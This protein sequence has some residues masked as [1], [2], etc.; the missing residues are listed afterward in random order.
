MTSAQPSRVLAV[1][2]SALTLAVL[3]LPLPAASSDVMP[4]R[5]D[6]PDAFLRGVTHVVCVTFPEGAE[7]E[8][9]VYARGE[10]GF[11][12]TGTLPRGLT[13][14]LSRWDDDDG[15]QEDCYPA[16]E[17]VQVS[18]DGDTARYAHVLIDLHVP[19]GRKVWLREGGESGPS[20]PWVT[21]ESLR[22]LEPFEDKR[23]EFHALRRRGDPLVVRESPRDEARELD[24]DVAEDVILGQ[25]VGDYAEVV[26][27]TPGQGGYVRVGWVRMVDAQGLL[28]VWPTHFQSHGC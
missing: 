4:D 26:A 8:L 16:F 7:A 27:Y 5:R 14:P 21:I 28:L 20:A 13:G 6:I 11:R 2:S 15:W 12:Q 22:T 10:T 19:G 24:V 18:G 25:R 3:A 23:V 17:D 1:L 9:P